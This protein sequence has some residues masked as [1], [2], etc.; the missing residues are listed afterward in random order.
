MRTELPLTAQ[1]AAGNEA[2]TE[3]AFRTGDYQA[4]EELL[5]SALARAQATGERATEATALDRLGWLM[6][7]QAIDRELAGADPDAEEELFTRALAIRRELDDPAG[8][9]ESTFGVGLVRQVLR[10][11]WRTAI[12]RFREA[13]TLAEPHGGPLIR[14][15]IHRHIG[16][17]YLVEQVDLPLAIDHLRTS[18]R[19]RE[20]HGD[21]RWIPSGMLALGQALLIAGEQAEAVTQLRE[22]VRA[23]RAARLTP[24]RVE[25]AELWLGR[26]ERGERPTLG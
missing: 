15:E 8:I 16:F 18:L 22:A 9:A 11:D 6:H 2:L 13:L 26:A 4:A 20:Q 19:L 21:D 3:A 7:F 14:S 10:Q 24:R 25:Q 17:Y 12:D 23:S 1:L 5:T